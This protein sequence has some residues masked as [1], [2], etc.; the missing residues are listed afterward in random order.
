VHPVFFF[1]RRIED[2]SFPPKTKLPKVSTNNKVTVAQGKLFLEV[3]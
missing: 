3:I 1:Q 2:A